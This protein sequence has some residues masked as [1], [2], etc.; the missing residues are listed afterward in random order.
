MVRRKGLGRGLDALLSGVTSPGV[1]SPPSEQLR[2]LPIERVQRSPF[3]PRLSIDEAGI[4]ELAESIR[5]RGI[6]QP[7]LVRRRAIDGEF[8]L[9]AGERRWRAAQ[10]AQL[11]EIPAIVREL[12]DQEA[13]AIALIENIQRQD[14]NAIEEAVALHRLID[15]FQLTHQQAAEAVGRSRAAVTNLL[16]LLDLNADVRALATAGELDMGQ[17]RAL[18]GLSG[19]AQSAAA[20]EVVSRGLSTRQTEQLVRR[21]KSPVVSDQRGKS[22]GDPNVRRLEDD[23]SARLG[24]KVQIQSGSRGKGKLVVEYSSLDELDGILARIH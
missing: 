2:L 7:V 13:A 23:L 3:Q 20:L 21:L 18:L 17:A 9:V 1:D 14:L 4:A 6:L 19:K 11:S 15:E 24:A 16:R 10:L 22:P 5:S 12:S 8:E